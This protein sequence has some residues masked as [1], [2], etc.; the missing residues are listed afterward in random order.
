MRAVNL[1]QKRRTGNAQFYQVAKLFELLP[2]KPNELRQAD[3]TYV[4]VPG[5]GWWH[6]VTVIEYYSYYLLSCNYTPS[7][8]AQDLNVAPDEAKREVQRLCG[9]LQKVLFSVTDNCQHIQGSYAH[10]RNAYRIPTQLGLLERFYQTLKTAEIYW[11]LYDSPAYARVCLA[12]IHER[13]NQV[14][15]HWA[16][17]PQLSGDPVTTA[18]VYVDGVTIGLPRWRK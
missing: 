3:V 12:E 16:L 8:Q 18:E 6:A 2:S 14:P 10:I 5:H 17:I 15:P 9:R 7:H 4:R 13:Y 1:L 11:R